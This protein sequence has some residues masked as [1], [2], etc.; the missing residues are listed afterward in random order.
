MPDANDRLWPQVLAHLRAQHPEVRRQWFELLEPLG[1][2][3]GVLRVR[4]Q[5]TVHRD[6]LD[7]ECRKAFSEAA[8]AA[9]G[10]LLSVQFLGPDET[11]EPAAA[12]PERPPA[13]R[14]DALVINPD[15]SFEHFI[16]GP[17]NRLAHAAA[18]AVAEAPGRTYN[19]LFIH[20]GVGLG[21]THLLQAVC[22]KV[23]ARDPQASIH[24]TSCDSFITR[25]MDAVQAGAMSNFRNRFRGVDVLIVDDIHFLAKRD[26][27]Q[28][29]F[30]HTFNSLHQAGKQIV[31]SSDAAPEEIPH[32]EKRLVSR[33]N[34][35]VVAPIQQPGYETRVAILKRKATLRGV[36]LPDDVIGYVATR[37]DTNIRELEGTIIRLQMQSSV[38]E[39]PIDLALAQLVVGDPPTRANNEPTIQTVIS[40]VIEFYGIRLTDL[41]SKRRHRSVTIPRQICM[42]L[43]REHT[44]HSLE[45][46]GG[47][48]GGRDHTTVMHAVKTVDTRR[49][50]DT[51]FDSVLVAL[52]DRLRTPPA[53]T[54]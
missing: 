15:F 12:Q 11:A 39:R 37:V 43:A 38:D 52:G 30:F 36:D 54:A 48:F 9:T 47:Y 51:E 44:N 22:L 3:G 17:N 46:I 29:E 20:G 32:L 40:A 5:S 31:L 18:L 13:R 25:Y 7:R 26:R 45:E 1:I 33:F 4:A 27:S 24:L 21:K 28:E 14:E 34:S 10:M 6:Y 35:G 41:Q 49:K 42:Y 53:R 50:A 2:N 23:L 8:R 19:P 16:I